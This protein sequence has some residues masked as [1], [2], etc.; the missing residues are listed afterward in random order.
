MMNERRTARVYALM[1]MAIMDATIGC[2]D[3]KHAYWY[4]RPHQADSTITTPVGR[5]NF[6]AYPSAYS[7]TPAAGATVVAGLFA[8]AKPAM[9]AIIAEA[10]IARIYAGLHFRFD[11]TAGQELGIKVARLAL[12]RSPGPTQQISLQ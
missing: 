6:P 8:A 3:A 2:W 9:D 5:P 11:I 10:S 1:H 12:A 4:N 7:C